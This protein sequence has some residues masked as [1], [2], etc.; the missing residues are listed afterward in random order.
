MRTKGP[1]NHKYPQVISPFGKLGSLCVLWLAV[2]FFIPLLPGIDLSPI[3]L[4][5]SNFHWVRISFSL[6]PYPH[7]HNSSQNRNR[8]QL[9]EHCPKADLK[10]E[11]QVWY[12]GND[13]EGAWL[14]CQGWGIRPFVLLTLCLL[15]TLAFTTC[16]PDTILGDTKSQM[17][18][19][20]ER[21]YSSTP[22]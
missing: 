14:T 9:R 16:W 1:S 11:A 12:K 10:P 7:P 13:Q 18:C 19:Q 20:R 22:N 5:G 8:V 15:N 4:P 17:W 2:F 3:F 21:P 6:L